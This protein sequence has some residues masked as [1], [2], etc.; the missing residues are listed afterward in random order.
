MF[1]YVEVGDMREE[2][3]LV[4]ILYFIILFII[5][6]IMYRFYNLKIY[7]FENV[8]IVNFGYNV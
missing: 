2:S 1:I 6:I 3:F 5:V 4:F 7:F 8:K